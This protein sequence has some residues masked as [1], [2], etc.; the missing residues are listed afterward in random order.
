MTFIRKHLNAFLVGILLLTMVVSYAANQHRLADSSP[1]VALPVVQVTTSPSALEDYRSRREDTL[2]TD[3]AA[4]QALCESETLDA[5]SRAD[6]AS[7]LQRL[8]DQRQQQSAL[9]GALSQSGLSP[10]V[11]VVTEGSV[12]VVT[13]RTDVSPAETALVMT[14][15]QAHAGVSPSGVRIITSRD[16]SP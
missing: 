4:L 1:T 11:A 12:T 6:A 16:V 15:A 3:M 2:L 9:E 14:L 10:C 8:I 13:G 7:R 5:V